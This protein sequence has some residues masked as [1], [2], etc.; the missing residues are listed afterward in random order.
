MRGEIAWDEDPEVNENVVVCSF[1]PHSSSNFST[2]RPCTT[3]YRLNCGHGAFQLYNKNR[4]DSFVF[5][6][7]KDPGDGL[8]VSIALQK[9]SGG[10]Q[11]VG[12]SMLFCDHVF[13]FFMS[14]TGTSLA[15]ADY[16]Y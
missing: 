7:A 10:V 3:G 11:K 13:T 14:A 9:I 6:T 4:R 8:R 16:W 15:N 1:L 2:Y 12:S 5:I